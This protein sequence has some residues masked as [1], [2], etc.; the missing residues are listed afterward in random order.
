[1]IYLMHFNLLPL[2]MRQRMHRFGKAFTV[3]GVSLLAY[4]LIASLICRPAHATGKETLI[5]VHGNAFVPESTLQLS[6]DGT[7]HMTWGSSFMA[8][9]GTNAW[10]HV[11]L[12]ATQVGVQEKHFMQW[13]YIL[14]KSKTSVI[15]EVQLWDGPFPV[16]TFT[17]LSLSGTHNVTMDASNQFLVQSKYPIS[18]GIGISVRV[19]F[20]NDGTQ[21]GRAV[22][23]IMFTGAGA[24]YAAEVSDA[25]IQRDSKHTPLKFEPK[26]RPA[27]ATK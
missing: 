14:F 25:Q 20:G 8:P 10:F 6:R 15:T 27:T 13:V 3:L 22:G 5:R 23:E 24:L 19:N 11:P 16:Q 26:L 4:L 2:V 9:A 18:M 7:R 1:M 17:N 12:P 21:D